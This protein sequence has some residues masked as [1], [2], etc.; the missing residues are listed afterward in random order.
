FT[1]EETW[2][3]KNRVAVLSHGLW[4]TRFG[5]NQ[6]IV[7]KQIALNGDNYTVLGVMP[8]DFLL[9]TKDVQIWVPFGWNPNTVPQ[10]RVAHYLRVVG[11]LKPGVT[12]DQARQEMT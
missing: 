12:L 6:E 5:G 11:R 2:V 8:H 1:P 9:P 4:Q 7:G 3:G 10:R